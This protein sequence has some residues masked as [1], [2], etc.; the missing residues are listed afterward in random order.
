[1]RIRY[2]AFD[3]FYPNL[4]MDKDRSSASKEALMKAIEGRIMANKNPEMYHR[5]KQDLEMSIMEWKDSDINSYGQFVREKQR[6]L[7]KA[8]QHTY[9]PETWNEG[10]NELEKGKNK[11]NIWKNEI[12]NIIEKLFFER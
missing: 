9:N 10:Y 5:V 4:S 11:T 6:S 2:K 1:M 3:L 8:G 7:M 12:E